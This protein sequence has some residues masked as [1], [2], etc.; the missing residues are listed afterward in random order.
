M[1]RPRQAVPGLVTR[2]LHRCL[3][4]AVWMLDGGMFDVG[5]L[6]GITRGGLGEQL[7]GVA[8][9]SPWAMGMPSRCLMAAVDSQPRAQVDLCGVPG[10]PS[11]GPFACGSCIRARVGIVPGRR[12]DTPRS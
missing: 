7:L 6:E 5:Y 8:P 1:A 11:S 4:Q 12:V 9:P 10:G 3:R 2:P